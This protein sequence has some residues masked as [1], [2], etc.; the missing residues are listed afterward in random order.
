M[1]DECFAADESGMRPYIPSRNP[2]RKCSLSLPT[3]AADTVANAAANTVDTIANAA[4]NAVGTH[5]RCGRF[6]LT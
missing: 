2:N 1:A 5:P 6:Q 3:D 4:A